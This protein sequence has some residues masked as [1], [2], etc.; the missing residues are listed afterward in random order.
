MRERNAACGWTTAGTVAGL[1]LIAVLAADPGFAQAAATGSATVADGKGADAKALAVVESEAKKKEAAILNG[2]KTGDVTP[3]VEPKP[4][5]LDQKES[6]RRQ[7]LELAAEQLVVEALKAYRKSQFKDA[8][9]FYRRA[10]GKLRAASTSQP[11][12]VRKLQQIQTALFNLHSDWADSLAREAKRMASLDKYDQAIQKCNQAAEFVPSRAK[13]MDERVK[14]YTRAKKSAE[15]RA[16]IQP[17]VVDPE[18]AERDFEINILLE[19]GKVFFENNRF[20]DARDL[21]EQILLKDP[22]DIRAIRYLR[23][24][25]D[26]LLKIAEEKRQT[27]TAEML[28]EVRWKWNWPVT[29]LLAG[30]AARVGGSAINKTREEKGIRA[31]LDNIIIPEVSFEDAKIGEV[32]DFLKKRSVELD[33]DGEGVNIMLQLSMPGAAPQQQGQGGGRNARHGRWHGRPRNGNGRR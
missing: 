27:T 21:F 30:P 25:S 31:K 24:I 32:I 33:P 19:Q 26:K 15:F 20:A 18:K 10:Q 3:A 17:Q 12:I 6:V 1:V 11:R 16:A 13:E 23:K 8:A 14:L 4:E 28:A 2:E 9:V 22:Y 7:E 29:P 5:E